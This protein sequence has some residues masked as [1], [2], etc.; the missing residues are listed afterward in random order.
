M[1]VVGAGVE[2][3]ASCGAHAWA[4]TTEH[5]LRP[6]ARSRKRS[7]RVGLSIP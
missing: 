3:S 1:L 7:S 6:E 5:E 4:L 2:L